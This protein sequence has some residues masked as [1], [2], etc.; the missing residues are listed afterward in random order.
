MKPHDVSIIQGEALTI[1]NYT[2]GAAGTN[3]TWGVGQ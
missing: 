3:D 1:L 2:K